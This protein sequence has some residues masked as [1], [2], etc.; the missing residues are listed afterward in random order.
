MNVYH[1]PHPERVKR[2]QHIE[3]RYQKI[4]SIGHRIKPLPAT[5]T[6][7][8][9]KPKRTKGRNLL[10][11]LIKEQEAVLAFAF[12]KE[13]PVT[14]NLAERDIRPT[15]LKQK[16]SNC[17]R[18]QTGADIYARIE[19]F[20]STARKHNHSVFSELCA[21]F[22]GKNFLSVKSS[23]YIITFILN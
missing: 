4:R 10:E 2:R 11:R 15:K 17:F 9:G 18:T 14:N 21:T 20:I 23:S 22:E 8:R 16:I 6:G 13:V 3:T 19:S 1:I 7:R 12:N 5:T